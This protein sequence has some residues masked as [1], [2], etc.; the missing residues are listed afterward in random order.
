MHDVGNAL[1]SREPALLRIPAARGWLRAERKYYWLFAISGFSG[2]IYESIWTHYLKLFL[3]H[4]AYAQSL[5]LAI[6]MGGMALGAWLCGRWSQRCRNLLFAYAIVEGVVGIAALIF[7]PLFVT[8]VELTL[9]DLI[10]LLGS[11]AEITALKWTVAGA[12]ILPQSI[13]LGATFP[14]MSAG[15]VRRFAQEPGRCIATLYFANSIGGAIGVLSSGFWLVRLIGLPGTIAVAGGLNVLLAI[16]VAALAR[17]A[18]EPAFR[19]VAPAETRQ[20]ASASLAPMLAVAA[21]TGLSSFIYEIGWVRMLSLVLGGSTHAFELMLSSFIFGLAIGGLWVRRRIDG[22][23]APVKFLGRVQLVMGLCALATLPLYNLSFDAMQ[24]LIAQLPKTDAGYGGFNLASHVIASAIMMPAAVC[25]GMTL[26]LITFALIKA[27]T[28]ERSIGLV[29]GA[30]TVGAIVGVFLAVHAGMPLLGLKNLIVAGAAVD[31]TLG[32]WLLRNYA[33]RTQARE[34]VAAAAAGIAALALAS[35]IVN[36]DPLKI[37]SGTFRGAN[38]RILTDDKAKLLFHGDGKTASISLLEFADHVVQVRTN[39]KSDASINLGPSGGYQIDEV[40][41]VLSGALPLLLKPDARNAAN[42]GMGSGLTSHVLLSDPRLEQV[43][44]IEIEEQMVAAARGFAPRNRLAYEDPRSIITIDDAKTFFFSRQKRYDVI[45]SEPS[46]PWVSGV[47]SLFS[48]EFHQLARRYLKRDGVLVQWLQ[49]YEIDEPLVMSVIKSLNSNFGDFAI[50]GANA[51]DILIVA[52]PGHDLPQLPAGFPPMPALIAELNH[53]GINSPQDIA[54]RRIATKRSLAPLLESYPIEINSD[55]NPVLDQNASRVRFIGRA[56]SGLV[57]VATEPLPLVEML[58]NDR[59]HWTRTAVTPNNH[60]AKTHPGSLAGF[61][62]DYLL[63]EPTSGLR[64]EQTR[65][66]QQQVREMLAAC[67]R[68]PD[69]DMAFAFLR[70]GGLLA[71]FLRPEEMQRLWPR[72]ESLPC[73]RVLYDVQAD[74]LELVK[75]IGTRDAPAMA[76]TS[77]R[78]FANR[79]DRTPLRRRFLLAAGML[80]NIADGKPAGARTLWERHAADALQ[81]SSPSLML[82]ILAAHAGVVPSR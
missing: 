15:V 59:P 22:F 2:L 8:T 80:G 63:G 64:P 60:F 30:N 57:N 38:Y 27:G 4:A 19:Q 78:L 26:P 11:P 47:S 44:T 50:Y 55:Y 35:T 32:I 34:P 25:A 29:Y 31:I 40:T 74:W 51:G 12:L 62:R 67:A 18:D 49:L 41:M 23:T 3:G 76:E 13:L 79:Q 20:L 46:N 7:H 39:G 52:T 16:T 68:P 77:L 17:G 73:A 53:I 28:G 65:A 72:V 43:D 75:A 66:F 56:A 24:V 33:T 48:T 61:F 9:T 71:A 69:G 37:V 82:R 36:F 42:I 21:L 5:V 54:V 1:P 14:L 70:I 6:F 10:P 58:S 45:V 81:N